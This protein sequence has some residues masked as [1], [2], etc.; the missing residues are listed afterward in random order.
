MIPISKNFRFR[1]VDIHPQ[2][3]S[4]AVC[5][6]TRW[7]VCSAVYANPNPSRREE[8]WAHLM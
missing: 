6:D 4:V 2:V 8:L 3:V 7:S 5:F 1:I